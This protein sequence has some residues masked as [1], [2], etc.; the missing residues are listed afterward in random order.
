M[1]TKNIR[2]RMLASHR[3][4]D[5][6]WEDIH[7]DCTN[8]RFVATKKRYRVLGFAGTVAMVAAWGEFHDRYGHPLA[9]LF[10]PNVKVLWLIL[11]P[12]LG[13][14]YNQ[15]IDYKQYNKE[16]NFKPIE[17]SIRKAI[18]LYKKSITSDILIYV[19]MLFWLWMDLVSPEVK[20]W[21]MSLYILDYL[22]VTFIFDDWKKY[23]LYKKIKKDAGIED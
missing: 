23:Q 20:R 12:L 7:Y 21:T 16:I 15:I 3:R 13:I 17:L 10:S 11:V 9:S 4:D 5:G 18:E 19:F 6:Y 2:F 1:C 22:F 14:I 8:K